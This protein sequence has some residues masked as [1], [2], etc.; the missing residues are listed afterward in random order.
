MKGLLT[1]KKSTS[2]I[3]EGLVNK[4]FLDENNKEAFMDSQVDPFERDQ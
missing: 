2:F 4:P 1:K 3:T